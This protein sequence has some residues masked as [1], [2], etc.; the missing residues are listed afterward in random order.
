MQMCVGTTRMVWD[1]AGSLKE[2]AAAL[3]AEAEELN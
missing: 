3:S 2:Q 1:Q